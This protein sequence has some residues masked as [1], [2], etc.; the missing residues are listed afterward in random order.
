MK[1]INELKKGDRVYHLSNSSLVMVVLDLDHNS[2]MVHCRWIDKTG[3]A[4][5]MDFIP[6]E[7]GNYD[8]YTRSMAPRIR[9]L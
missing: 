1:T 8:D 6:E 2:N 3:K 9:S 7:L 5:V 4:N